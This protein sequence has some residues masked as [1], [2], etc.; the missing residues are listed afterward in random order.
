[1]QEDPLYA[2]RIGTAVALDDLFRRVR[3]R[4][5]RLKVLLGLAQHVK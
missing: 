2:A 5:R 4:D 3:L 1:L